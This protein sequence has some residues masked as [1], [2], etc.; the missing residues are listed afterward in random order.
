VGSPRRQEYTVLGDTTNTASRLESFD[1]GMMDDEVTPGGCRILIGE[2]TYLHVA[3][4]VRV[5]QIGHCQLKGREQTVAIYA[6]LGRAEP[7]V[8]SGNGKVDITMN[9]EDAGSPAPPMTI[10]FGSESKS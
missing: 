5:R 7:Q 4:L 1:K 2:S 9:H 8:V 3:E 6:V 10:P